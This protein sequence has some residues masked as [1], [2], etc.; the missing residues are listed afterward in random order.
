MIDMNKYVHQL[1][2]GNIYT[3]VMETVKTALFYLVLIF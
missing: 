3:D 1:Y 2:Q